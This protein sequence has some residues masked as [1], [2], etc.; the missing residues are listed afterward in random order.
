MTVIRLLLCIVAVISVIIASTFTYRLL[1][2]DIPWSEV[3]KAIIASGLSSASLGLFIISGLCLLG[4][5]ITFLKKE[6]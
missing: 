2:V 6:Q 3:N 5:A 4:L 1:T